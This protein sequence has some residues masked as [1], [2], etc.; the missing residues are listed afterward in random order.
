LE[1]RLRNGRKSLPEEPPVHERKGMETNSARRK[2]GRSIGKRPRVTR[3]FNKGQ[4]YGREKKKNAMER[5]QSNNRGAE[6][7]KD[8]DGNLCKLA[9]VGKKVK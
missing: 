7:K 5:L 1:V 4:D 3:N 9:L 2:K 8:N 6:K